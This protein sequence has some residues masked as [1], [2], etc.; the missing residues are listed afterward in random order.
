MQWWRYVQTVINGDPGRIVYDKTGLDPSVI[1]RWRKGPGRPD[2]VAAFA[3]GYGRPVLEAFVAAGFLTAEEAAQLPTA[4]PSPEHL[5]D[6]ALLAELGDRLRSARHAQGTT[7]RAG[8][9]PAPDP[10]LD[11]LP[12]DERAAIEA[13]RAAALTRR[14]RLKD[15]S[16]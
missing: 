13:R 8:E 3:R 4:P 12:P 14:T 10:R 7:T 11:T 9:S 1:S 16:G 15:T 5:T 6:D 2:N